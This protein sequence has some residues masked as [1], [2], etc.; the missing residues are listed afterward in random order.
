MAS[1]IRKFNGYHYLQARQDLEIEDSKHESSISKGDTFL[2]GEIKG[3]HYI[4]DVDLDDRSAYRFLVNSK[5]YIKAIEQSEVLQ[6]YE[7]DSEVLDILKTLMSDYE[8]SIPKALYSKVLVYVRQ[9][10]TKIRKGSKNVT[11]KIESTT[12]R[13][14]VQV[15]KRAVKLA[16]TSQT[17]DN[18]KYVKPA[19][20]KNLPKEEYF[21]DYVKYL[22]RSGGVSGRY[23][24]TDSVLNAQHLDRLKTHPLYGS[25]ELKAYIDNHSRSEP[26]VDTSDIDA[27]YDQ[28]K[29]KSKYN[30]QLARYHKMLDQLEHSPIFANASEEDLEKERYTISKTYNP[31]HVEESKPE[32]VRTPEEIFHD[33]FY[34]EYASLYLRDVS[35]NVISTEK[36]LSIVYRSL[37]VGTM[38]YDDLREAMNRVVKVLKDTPELKGF[39]P[40]VYMEPANYRKRSYYLRLFL[41]RK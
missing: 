33:I 4:V 16:A 27:A 21:K 12:A 38:L 26:E 32:V 2:V 41:F 30:A 3:K 8:V 39:S 24:D 20:Y 10:N 35:V 9:R 23:S 37:P 1:K 7:P 5:V 40:K 11:I 15:L 19:E 36:S 17:F 13:V 29:A 6:P 31:D 28:G 25:K 18:M 34:S 22:E 14:M